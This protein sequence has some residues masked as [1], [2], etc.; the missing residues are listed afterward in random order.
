MPTLHAIILVLEALFIAIANAATPEE[1]AIGKFPGY[2]HGQPP[3]QSDFLT[4]TFCYCAMD[5]HEPGRKE[6]AHYFQ[7]EYYN[8]HA[9]TTFI[10]E[11]LCEAAKDDKFTCLEPRTGSG[12]DRN[13]Q[14][15]SSWHGKVCRSWRR[16]LNMFKKDQ[17]CYIPHENK[18]SRT[19][20]YM[21]YNF[22]WRNLGAGGGQAPASK[23][24]EIVDEVCTDFCSVHTGMPYLTD[25]K[26]APNRI[27][28]Y[29]DLD[30]MCDTCDKKVK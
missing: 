29:E 4:S 17:F 19:D 9:D 30:D 8:I 1:V 20:D 28:I 22:Q 18:F 6:E 11:H 14:D 26:L 21:E 15:R 10:L 25:S 23:P 3:F 13:E 2:N 27:I 5:G 24:R 16:D 7:F 12:H